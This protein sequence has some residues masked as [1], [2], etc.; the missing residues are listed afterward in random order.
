MEQVAVWQ[1]LAE[2]WL[3]AANEVAQPAL[4][5]CYRERAAAYERLVTHAVQGER[6]APVPRHGCESRWRR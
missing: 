5:L 4:K 2:R 1:K 3:E 6:S